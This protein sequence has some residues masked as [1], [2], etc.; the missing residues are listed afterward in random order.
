MYIRNIKLHAIFAIILITIIAMTQST[1]ANTSHQYRIADIP[2][3]IID[4]DPKILAKYLFENPD[5]EMA[6]ISQIKNGDKEW[7]SLYPRLISGTDASW[8]EGL[9]LSIPYALK[10]SPLETLHA[11]QESEKLAPELKNIAKNNCGNTAEGYDEDK[12]QNMLAKS[13][14]IELDLRMVALKKINDSTVLETKRQC[15]ESI[16]YAQK[17]WKKKIRNKK[18]RVEEDRLKIKKQKSHKKDLV[19]NPSK[20]ILVVLE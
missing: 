1:L 7:L 4:S 5:R 20:I 13:S 18:S 17:E 2:K 10:S 11:I 16:E 19:F 8:T 15:I 12:P 9:L 6:F 14:L 3:K